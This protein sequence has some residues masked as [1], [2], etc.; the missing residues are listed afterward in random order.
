M[1]RNGID[2]IQEEL[3]KLEYDLEYKLPKKWV[4]NSKEYQVLVRNNMIMPKTMH[5]FRDLTEFYK[6]KLA[7]MKNKEQKAHLKGVIEGLNIGI[8]IISEIP[9]YGV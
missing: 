7:G 4:I 6:S 3:K 5:R 9:L 8:K 2:E 1:K